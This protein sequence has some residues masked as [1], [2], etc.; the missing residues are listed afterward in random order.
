[1]GTQWGK[2]GKLTLVSTLTAGFF[3]GI[4][5]PA[6]FAVGASGLGHRYGLACLPPESKRLLGQALK[7]A[8]PHEEYMMENE[9]TEKRRRGDKESGKF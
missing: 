3:G 6:L 1:V 9:E 2:F 5:F 8:F 7:V 4:C